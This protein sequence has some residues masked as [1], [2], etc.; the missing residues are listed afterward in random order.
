MESNHEFPGG[1]A[2]AGEVKKLYASGQTDYTLE[3]IILEDDQGKPL[4]R[5]QPDDAVVFCCR[6]GEREIQLTEAFTEPE[7]G[8]FKR[9]DL[10]PD[11][12]DPDPLP[13]EIQEPAGGVRPNPH[14]G[15][16]R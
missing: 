6:R 1:H 16:T 11:L 14:P 3:P 8:G 4:G 12:R 9:W 13:R 2:L 7:T 15:H 5:I 10:K